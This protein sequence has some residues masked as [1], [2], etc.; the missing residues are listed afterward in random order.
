MADIA[1]STVPSEHQKEAPRLG[2]SAS[3]REPPKSAHQSPVAAVGGLNHHA[4]DVSQDSPSEKSKTPK[5]AKRRTVQVEYVAPQSQ[6]TRGEYQDTSGARTRDEP[7]ATAVLE[8]PRTTSKTAPNPPVNLNKPLP[9]HFPR[10]TSENPGLTG[11]NTYSTVPSNTRPQTGGSM[12]SFHTGRLP[13][14]GSYGQ[15]VAPTVTATN[16]EGRLAQ[17]KSGQFSLAQNPAQASNVSIG[18]PST[19]QLPSAFNPTPR[20][21]P[22]KSGHKRSSTVSSIGERLFGRSGSILGGRNSQVPN[23]RPRQNKRYPPTS[24]KDP[25][26]REDSRMSMDSRRSMQYG[27][28]RKA[29]EAEGRPRRFSL[30]P[31]SFSFRNFS[32]RTQTPEESSQTPRTVDPQSQQRPATGPMPN[33]PRATSYGTQEAMS[34]VNEGPADEVHEQKD[35]RPLS[36]EAQIDQQFAELGNRFDQT[37]DSFGAISSEQ[38]YHNADE[39]YSGSNYAYSSKPNYYD[40]YNGTY[41]SL[42]RQSMQQPARRGPSVLQKNHR[43]FADAYEYERDASHHSGSSG[44]ARK[45]MDF[46]RRRA[47]S[48]AGDDR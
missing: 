4:G 48:R 25:L 47:K 8:K 33:R 5:D 17:P 37:D 7:Q 45:V 40:D 11:S 41:D 1:N 30:L 24:M 21:E 19:Q 26:A 46:F 36:Y 43:K 18:R 9:G 23:S 31:S 28:N 22:P 15:P 16:T 12:A 29:S 35:S 2:R 39:Q 13:S 20:Q 42:P 32:G 6:T 44:A 27:H 34:M 38:G 14:R 3:V 10:S